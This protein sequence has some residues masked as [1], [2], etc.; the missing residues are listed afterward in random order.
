MT[1]SEYNL[2]KGHLPDHPMEIKPPEKKRRKKLYISERYKP[3][4]KAPRIPDELDW[5]KYGRKCNK[6][7]MLKHRL[8]V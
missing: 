8:V 7:I 2:H 1:E 3:H 4:R 6:D 5:R